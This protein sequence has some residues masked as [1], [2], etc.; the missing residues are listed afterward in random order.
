[1]FKDYDKYFGATLKVYLFVLCLTFILKLVGLDY[2]G[3]TSDF[4]LFP[5]KTVY[6]IY[7]YVLLYITTLILLS[8][9]CKDKSKKMKLFVLLT[10]PLSFLV[11]NL[12]NYIQSYPIYFIINFV[13]LYLLC[14]IYTKFKD[15]KKVSKR[16]ILFT[17]LNIFYQF[18]SLIT[19]DARID[20]FNNSFIVIFILNFDYILM[21]LISYN[22][23]FK[24]GGKRTWNHYQVEEV[25]S[26]S[27]KKTNL[28][29]LLKK[30]QKN[31]HK[32]KSLDKE[33]KIA[34]I[35]Y[36]VLS[37]IWNIFTLV[38]VLFIAKLNNT[39]VE[40]IFIIS[41]FW[42]SKKVF[43]TPFHLKSMI[44]CFIVSNLTYYILNRITLNIGISIF[45]Q[46][47][48][49]VGLSYVTS[50]LVKKMYKPLYRGMP[51]EQFEETILKVTDKGSL[52]YNICYDYFINRKSSISLSM[53]YNYS[54][55]GID[56]IKD[57]I[58]AKIKEL[59]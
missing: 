9:S 35:V 20:S 4:D 54:K 38:V 28:K 15:V 26:S 12:P 5:S 25:G 47:L 55:D 53:K 52:K 40:C 37:S 17:I 48:L 34:G 43:G 3:I 14:L 41:S 1:M 31:W 13:Y 45:V 22:L 44:Q 27:Q 30:L 2:F 50:K 49:G 18:I 24:I 57:R 51:K 42:M 7:T 23:Y 36:F 19:R 29:N 39:L 56:K 10:Y 32:F 11:S 21:L 8:I 58:N 16:Y 59:N 33:T 46:I 6:A